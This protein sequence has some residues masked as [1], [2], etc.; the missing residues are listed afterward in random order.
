MRQRSACRDPALFSRAL[1]LIAA[2]AGCFAL[3]AYAG[4]HLATGIAIIAYLG[5]FGCL[6]SLPLAARRSAGFSTVLMLAL[7]AAAGLAM[8][9]T[10]AYY[11]AA[12]PRLVWQAGG[13]AGLF[14]AAC[15]LAG[16]LARPGLPWLA[17]VLLSEALAMA[18]C[19][20]VLVSEYMALPSIGWAAMAV[21]AYFSLAVLGISLVWRTRDFASAPLLAAS[22]FAAPA[23]ALFLVA[24][25]SL[26]LA[27]SVAFGRPAGFAADPAARSR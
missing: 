19:G 15:G 18:L 22:V 9:A 4:P 23:G 3:G 6:L 24:R 12:D 10:A 5:V 14:T 27:C 2:T 26:Q 8:A 11:A 25:N 20:I 13:M 1:G 16:Y 7:G 21:A 17:Q